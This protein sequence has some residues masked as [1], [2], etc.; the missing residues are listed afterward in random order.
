[1]N[2]KQPKRWQSSLLAAALAFAGTPLLFD[3]LVSLVR[4]GFLSYPAI[5]HSA[6]VLLVAVGLVLV[7]AEDSAALGDAPGQ[8]VSRRQL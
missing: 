7:L 2:Q 6:P 4:S 8:R 3:R 1:M 5:L